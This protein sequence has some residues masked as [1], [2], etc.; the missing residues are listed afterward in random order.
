[1]FFF[2]LFIV[3]FPFHLNCQFRS[4]KKYIFNGKELSLM[5]REGN[6]TVPSLFTNT[7]IISKVVFFYLNNSIAE[8]MDTR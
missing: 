7:F 4:L 6:G 3:Q 2:F 8:A 5:L 1:M